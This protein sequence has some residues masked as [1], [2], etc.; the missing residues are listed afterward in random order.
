[1]QGKAVLAVGRGQLPCFDREAWSHEAET[2]HDV[3]RGGRVDGIAA[4]WARCVWL[5]GERARS[6]A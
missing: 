1:M 4:G 3:G 5:G 6:G 2:P